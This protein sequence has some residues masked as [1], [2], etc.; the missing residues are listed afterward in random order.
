MASNPAAV[1]AADLDSKTLVY[2]SPKQDRL[3]TKTS[4]MLNTAQAL[5]IDSPTMFKAANDELVRIKGFYKQLDEQ[6]KSITKPM[7]D[8]KKAVMDLFR[9]PLTR[10]EQAE[11]VIKRGMLAY[12]QEQERIA[13]EEQ[14]RR[15]EVARKQREEAEA[16]ARKA[17]EEAKAQAA[18]GNAAAAAEKLAEAQAAA[19]V[20]AV[21]VAAPV[22]PYVPK[23]TGTTV[24]GTWKAKVTDKIALIKFIAEHPEWTHLLDI[25]ESQLNALARGQKADLKLPGVETWEE[26]GISARA[27]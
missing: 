18:A 16:A 25:N 6:R 10:L 5:V 26:K 3:L 19:Q 27:A 12:T 17:E 2:E 14:A 22:A 13:R 8:A 7:D 15:D 11:G 20:A 21:T 23:V 24:R 1:A 4:V 9:E